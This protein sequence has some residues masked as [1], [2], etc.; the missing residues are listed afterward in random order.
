MG[1]RVVRKVCTHCLT[2]Y[3]P[4]KEV[5]DNVRES[6]GPLFDA[7]VVNHKNQELQFAKG[8]GCEECSGT[9]YSGRIGIYEVLSVSEKIGRLIMERASDADIQRQ[10]IA[11]GMVLMKQDGYLKVLDG[12][13]TIEEV[14]RVAEIAPT[15]QT[16]NH[17][18]SEEIQP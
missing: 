14:L 17:Q 16:T 4:P 5:I 10:G 15:E 8:T 11:E 9:G 7:W 1:Q 6:L 13:T 3:T 2:K 18:E 12:A